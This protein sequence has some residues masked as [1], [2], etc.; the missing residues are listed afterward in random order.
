MTFHSP[1][2]TIGLEFWL[3]P[4]DSDK[5]G[6]LNRQFL[7]GC[8]VISNHFPFVKVWFIIQLKQPFFNG[9]VS[10]TRSVLEFLRTN[11]DSADCFFHLS[12]FN[13][14]FCELL[15]GLADGCFL[16]CLEASSKIPGPKKMVDVLKG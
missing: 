1:N 14:A 12:R 3:T 2:S 11:I 9:D 16:S 10:G 13:G 7:N 4:H 5:P 8:L 6:S 15:I